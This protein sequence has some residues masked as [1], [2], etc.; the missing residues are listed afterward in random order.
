MKSWIPLLFLIFLCIGCEN[1]KEPEASMEFKTG[2]SYASQDTT[3]S[4]GS[5]LTVGIVADKAENN[6]KAYNVS[7]SY[8]GAF[9]TIT[10]QNFSIASDENAHYDKD[11]N[12]TVRNLP[13]IEKYY[14]TI[15]DVDGNLLQ[16]MLSFTIE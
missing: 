13:G 8:D 16:K 12:L 5:S 2:A 1:E 11:V 9:N 7:V 15:E 6:F 10:I 4:M 3:I 14:F